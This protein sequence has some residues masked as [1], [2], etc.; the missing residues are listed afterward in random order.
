MKWACLMSNM[1]IPG[2]G[3][4]IA[5]RYGSGAVQVIGSLIGFG[6]LGYFAFE[7]V[8]AGQ[9]YGNSFEG[10]LD[11]F[12]ETLKNIVNG[13]VGPFICGAIGLVILK[14]TF[15]WA[16]VTTAQVFKAQKKA[17]AAEEAAAA[18][19]VPPLLDSSN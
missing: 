13:M 18:Q 4:M 5:K 17:E 3:S 12:Q 11:N 14:I 6:L 8:R 1:I 7:L 10:E 16:Q 19:A 2:A 15:I 9:N